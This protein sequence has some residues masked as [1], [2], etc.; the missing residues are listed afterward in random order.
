MDNFF[1]SN[2][3]YIMENVR[4]KLMLGQSYFYVGLFLGQALRLWQAFGPSAAARIDQ[5]PGAAAICPSLN[6]FNLWG[7]C[8]KF[9]RGEESPKSVLEEIAQMCFRVFIY[10]LLRLRP[11]SSLWPMQDLSE[12]YPGCAG[13]RQMRC[14][15]MQFNL[16]ILIRVKKNNLKPW[17]MLT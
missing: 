15:L 4:L 12:E 2:N 8:T 17:Y 1:I 3:C 9:I 16:G 6:M 5:G 10:L 13:N 11:S 7:P 14:Q